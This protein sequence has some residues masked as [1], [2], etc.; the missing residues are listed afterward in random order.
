MP[1]LLPCQLDFWVVSC[2]FAT[3]RAHLRTNRALSP[4]PLPAVRLH[5]WRRVRPPTGQAHPDPGWCHGHDDPALQ[6]GRGRFPW[7][8]LRRAPQ[9][10][11]GR[12]RT[13]VAGA[14]GRDRGNPPAVPRGRRR[15]DRDQHLRRHVDR[16]GR[17]RPAG[18]GLRDE[19]G[20]GPPGARRLRRLQHARASALRGRGAGAA[21]QDRVHLARR[22]R[23]GGAQ[24]HLRR[25]ARGLCRAAQW[26]AR[27]RHR[28]RPD[29]NHLRYAQRQG[30]HL[31]RR[32]SVRGARRAPAGDDFGHR[33]R[34]VGPHPVRPDR[35]G[36][37]ELGAP[38]AA[39]H[40]RPELRAGRGADASVCGRAVQDLRHLC[41]RLS[42]R[43]P[44]QSHGRDGL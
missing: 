1:I 30:G 2:L 11:Q 21:A 42:Q 8:A 25:A 14:P 5:A 3:P 15:R 19:P 29:R 44:A 36:V 9:G 40:H 12:Q 4:Y 24:R 28:H 38:C 39:G 10:S 37:L 13:A 27:R 43:R 33:D 26:P 34:C 17:L 18:A 6:A 16:P 20:V 32:G 7:R 22:Q 31:R 23:P 35:R 41:V